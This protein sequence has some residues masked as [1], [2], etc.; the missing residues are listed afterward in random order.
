MCTCKNVDSVVENTCTLYSRLL[1]SVTHARI[2]NTVEPVYSG[3]P[4]DHQKC[5]G[6][7]LKYMLH[8]YI[9]FVLFH[10]TCTLIR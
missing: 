4:G 6:D 10:L 8:V 3:H 5:R 7:R 1:A 9:P 2:G